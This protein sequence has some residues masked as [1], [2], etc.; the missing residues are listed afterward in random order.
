MAGTGSED[1]TAR[2]WDT[3]AQNLLRANPSARHEGKV[4][5]LAFSPDGEW[6]ATGAVIRLKPALTVPFGYGLWM[7]LTQMP[8]RSF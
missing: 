5:A 3:R 2:L 7:P 8:I 1:K 4:N 6:L